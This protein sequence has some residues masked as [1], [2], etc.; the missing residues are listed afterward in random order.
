M[1]INFMYYEKCIYSFKNVIFS[2]DN[3]EY[4]EERFKR[5]AEGGLGKQKSCKDQIK[6]ENVKNLKLQVRYCRAR[7]YSCRSLW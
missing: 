2:E 6:L 1:V 7:P 3:K 4:V 5:Y